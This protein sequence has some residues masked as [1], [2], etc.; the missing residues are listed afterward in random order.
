[1]KTKMF[2]L[3]ITTAFALHSFARDLCPY[4]KPVKCEVSVM[5]QPAIVAAVPMAYEFFAI[6]VAYQEAPV[7]QSPALGSETAEGIAKATACSDVGRSA[8]VP[9]VTRLKQ[10]TPA[11]GL[12]WPNVGIRWQISYTTD[13]RGYSAPRVVNRSFV[14]RE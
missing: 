11:N 8:P 9:Y 5:E 14:Q 12:I 3:L 1:M 4:I 2:L 13:K 10:E 6:P 7:P